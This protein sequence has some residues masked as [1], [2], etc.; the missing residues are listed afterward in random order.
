MKRLFLI[1][2]LAF[3]ATTAFAQL[4][5]QLHYDF[6]NNFYGKELSNR[7]K[8]T[9]TVENF[10]PDKWG[11]TYFFIDAD[12]GDNVMQSVYAELAREFK[13]WD[14]PVALHLEY[15]GGL[16]GGGSYNDVYLF[17][18]AYNWADNDFSK[19]FSVQA[20]YKYL[21]RQ[22]VGS[23]HSW[24]LT[25]VWGIH[26][27]DGLCSFTGFADLW[28]DNSVAGNLVFCSEPQFW[29][30]LSA[31]DKMDDDFKLSVGAELELSNCLV[32]PAYGM[33]NEFYA[34]PTLAVK[35]VF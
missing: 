20:M 28:H 14:A 22:Q 3:S 30:N 33:N 7:P 5:L 6:G 32:W 24:Q 12:L 19:T 9:A 10:T 34:I 21:A 1:A 23:H 17:G 27:A 8:L 11:S 29:L 16:S 15:N 2:L 4:N 18:G 35:W 25:T 31:M 26:F 13:F